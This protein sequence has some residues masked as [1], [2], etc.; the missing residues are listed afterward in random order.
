MR[1][2]P[3]LPRALLR[4]RWVLYSL[5]RPWTNASRAARFREGPPIR[6]LAEKGRSCKVK[7]SISA[8]KI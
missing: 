3:H 5:G 7:A 8:V 4:W 2:A 6:Q 1:N